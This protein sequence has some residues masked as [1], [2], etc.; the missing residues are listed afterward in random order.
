MMRTATLTILAACVLASGAFAKSPDWWNDIIP[1]KPQYSCGGPNCGGYG[2]GI[3]ICHGYLPAAT[4]DNANCGPGTHNYCRIQEAICAV[5]PGGVVMVAP[6]YTTKDGHTEPKPY[7]ENLFIPK[8]I[9]LTSTLTRR[10]A[11]ANS[12]GASIRDKI[13]EKATGSSP[14]GYSRQSQT[15]PKFPFSEYYDVSPLSQNLS[16]RAPQ[17]YEDYAKVF[18]VLAPPDNGRPCI[19]VDVKHGG[20]DGVRIVGLLIVAHDHM[21]RPCVDVDAPYFAFSRVWLLGDPNEDGILV[22]SGLAAITGNEIMGADVGVRLTG[23]YESVGGHPGFF[24][25]GMDSFDGGFYRTSGFPPGINREL[26][27]NEGMHIVADNFIHDNNIGLQIIGDTDVYTARNVIFNNWTAGVQNMNGGG[28]Y[29]ANYIGYNG[30]GFVFVYDTRSAD[31]TW[32]SASNS[33]PMSAREPPQ[34]G[35]REQWP[36]RAPTVIGNAIKSN[37][38][39]GVM[40]LADAGD[41]QNPD[42]RRHNLSDIAE[43]I[44]E[45][46]GTVWGN[47]ISSNWGHAIDVRAVRWDNWRSITPVDTRDALAGGGPLQFLG[48]NP[49]KHAAF[50]NNNSYNNN[51][52]WWSSNRGG[53]GMGALEDVMLH[54]IFISY[55]QRR[56]NCEWFP[57]PAFLQPPAPPLR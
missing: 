27:Y 41:Q 29:T 36:L 23:H 7:T 1:A 8:P 24:P 42:I 52:P 39:A 13:Y 16:A 40:V 55:P 32:T 15:G 26:P 48:I 44:Y 11:V 56:A 22:R 47:C 37:A 33:P 12:D 28:A 31:K 3:G 46:M 53:L 45:H 25:G 34:R 10:Q 30:N 19:G 17:L 14:E 5:R 20:S 49:D 6:G 21:T 50:P 54:P 43:H 51:G 38:N 18:P 2:Y 9:T 4:V 57:D 35:E